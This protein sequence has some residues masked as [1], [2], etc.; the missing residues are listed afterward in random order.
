MGNPADP[1]HVLIVDDEPSIREGS[2]RVLKRIDFRVSTAENGTDA[3]ELLDDDR[4][5]L[6]LLDMKM[7]G[8]DGMEVLQHIR[9]KDDTILIIVITGFATLETAVNAMKL[10][11]YDFIP[12]P[13]EPAQLRMVAN[14]ARD[15]I[16]L[17]QDAEKL[18]REKQRTL[19]DLDMEKSRIR[20][21]VESLPSGTVVTN[22]K[23]QVVLMNP[24]FRRAFSLPDDIPT[25]ET[26]DA[27]VEDPGLCNLILQISK[28]KHIDFDDIP[29][30]EFAVGSNRYLKARAR[31]VLGDRM[32]CLGAVV[33][34]DDITT[35]KV[36]DR[37]KSEFVAK[38]SHELRSPLSTIHEQLA[39]VLSATQETEGGSDQAILARAKE[40]T[41]GL[42]SL[43]GDLLDLSRIE[44][45]SICQELV[46]VDV[47]SMLADIV[48]FLN[49]RAK[50]KQQTLTM[51]APAAEIPP[52]QADPLALESIFGNL[53]ANAINYTGDGGTIDV[54]AGLAGV[55]VRVQVAD[56]GF[57]IEPRHQDRIFERFYRV[58]DDNTRYITG[59]G[60]GLPIVK[61][62]VTSLGGLIELQSEVGKGST[63]TVL[64]PASG[65]VSA[66]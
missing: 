23:G 22:S 47:T 43:I 17:M 48:S 12:K 50:T 24:S 28:G 37:L 59:T 1:L 60:L 15:R 58:K 13:F 64:L 3:L 6:V 46:P 27:Y 18:T 45:G 63:F 36:I 5:Q 33:S 8:M 10:G 65:R 16:L 19:L 11:A 66:S 26:I 62:L 20:T 9:E 49:T 52:I 29:A 35:M 2:K 61:E 31:P 42:I 34:I 44:E 4:A 55:N 32:E 25:G 41:H 56:T 39:V 40:K 51:K 53:I 57:G 14:R 54:S 7:P 21:I 30:Y 38:V